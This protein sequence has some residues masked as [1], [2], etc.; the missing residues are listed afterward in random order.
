[1]STGLSQLECAH[2]IPVF[3]VAFLHKVRCSFCVSYEVHAVHPWVRAETLCGEWIV[4]FPIHSMHI[5]GRLLTIFRTH[6]QLILRM[7]VSSSFKLHIYYIIYTIS[8]LLE[9]TVEIWLNKF[10]EPRSCV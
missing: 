3:V 10:L 7:Q 4:I 8:Y 2:R 9:R 6:C 1:M 5:V